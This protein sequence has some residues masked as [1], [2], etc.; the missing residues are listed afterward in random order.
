MFSHTW[1][2]GPTSTKSAHAPHAAP[3]WLATLAL[4]I[5]CVMAGSSH[6]ADPQISIDIKDLVVDYSWGYSTG[7][8]QHQ[9]SFKDGRSVH[10][11]SRFSR[12]NPNPN[13]EDLGN[14]DWLMWV[15]ETTGEASIHE[16]PV[17]EFGE[18]INPGGNVTFGTDVP[19]SD[20]GY[21]WWVLGARAE[22]IPFDLARS[23]A[24]FD[25]RDF[26]V[27]LN[28]F[29]TV[30]KSTAVTL[31]VKGQTGMVVYRYLRS[32]SP[33][34]KVLFKRFNLQ[35]G[36][37]TL[38]RVRELGWAGN[39]PDLGDITIEQ[40]WTRWDPRR[41]AMAAT[42]QW[43]AR[44]VSSSGAVTKYFGS[45]PFIYTE[46]FGETWRLADGSLATLP[47]TYAT[48]NATI[49]PY[50]HL[51]AH[52]STLWF[53]RD[54]G[55]T[56]NGTP[57]MAIPSGPDQ[58]MRFFYWAQNA[59]QMRT[60]TTDLEGGDPVACG[61]T[62]NYVVCLFS[63][64][65]LPG[66]LRMRMSADNGAT[67]SAPQTLD[68]IPRTPAG[69][70]QKIAWVSFVQPADGFPNDV[71]RFFYGYWDTNDG[72]N[73]RDYGNNMRWIR[74]ALANNDPT[75]DIT[76]PADVSSQ[77][78]GSTIPLIANTSDIDGDTV[79]VAW[80]ANGSSIAAPWTPTAGNYTVVA[81]ASD[82]R[83]GSATDS[84]NITVN[85]ANADPT[86]DITAPVDGS[87]HL[88]GTT[89]PLS[90]STDD[91]DGD[92]VTVAW[93][94]NGNPISAPWIPGAGTYTVV[95]NADDGNGGSAS[96]SVSISV[97]ANQDPTVDITAP[98]DG[99]SHIA[100]TAITLAA[101]TGD[102]DG[103]TVT[104]AW[105][106]NGNPI[107]EPWLPVA[108]SY[109]VAATASDGHGGSAND[110]VSITVREEGS[111]TVDIT[112]PL[113][114]SGHVTGTPIPLA[115]DTSD[116]DGDTVLVT[117]T[118][119]GTLIGEPWTPVAGS[120]TVVASADDGNGGTAT[121]SVGITVSDPN[122]DPT[123]NITSPADASSYV[124]GAPIP[125]SAD[126]DDPDGDT[127][128]VTW[129]ANGNPISA[130][131]A[132][133]AGNYTVVASADDGNGG[134]ASD[135]VSISV[136][137]NQNPT[138]DITSP[139]DGSSHVAGT[140]IALSATTGDPDGHTVTVSWTANG[141]AI[142]APWVPAAGNYTVVAS[143]SDGRGGTATDSVSVTVTNPNRNPTVDITSPADGSSYVSGSTI[144]LTATTGDPD[145]HPVAIA[146]TA[147]GN[148]IAAPWIPG[149]GTYT[150]VATASD[151]HG[152]TATDSVTT[153]V[154]AS[155]SGTLP[156]TV[157]AVGV[158]T[159]TASRML[160]TLNGAQNLTTSWSNNGSNS[161]AWFTLDLGSSKTVERLRIAP[162]GGVKYTF[163]VTIGN[164]V[165][166]G[167]V[168]GSASGTCAFTGATDLPTALSN[169]AVSGVG[170]YVTV[171][172]SRPWLVVYGVEAVGSAP[173]VSN[174]LPAT[175]HD[176]GSNDATSPR[177][178][179]L[180]NGAQN[181]TTNWTND[182]V[183]STAWFTLDLGSQ[184]SI[185][186]L[187]VA[188]RGGLKY[189]LTITIGN[190]VSGGKVTGAAT[191]TCTTSG[192]TTVPTALTLCGVSGT[193][194]YVTVQGNKPY[195]V[196]YGIEA[197][198]P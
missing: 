110:S 13:L 61:T 53:T 136:T 169:C 87:S 129:T 68:A 40:V 15:D 196:F 121:D 62:K 123:I 185:G 31:S 182:G 22:T 58:D 43:F 109:T 127:V 131:W 59:W 133:G 132:P 187:M 71:A 142:A 3:A 48:N 1:D 137:A 125:L 120:Y 107:A 192:G 167:K 139:V 42:W 113:D 98:V 140:T 11:V 85:A 157:L 8:K 30:D 21:M 10:A 166:G 168:S 102:A 83:G 89:I 164:T 94:A 195:L 77:E 161:T 193:G 91:P 2:L 88:A 170:R 108:G 122:Q 63:E 191:G 111:P 41:G 184:Q 69:A 60:L 197:W 130:G 4:A 14:P 181:L 24:P 33:V 173:P 101:S 70:L 55:F 150:V 5:V 16:H 74:V 189:T 106:A 18:G 176:A 72:A 29:E 79:T 156:A 124:A 47:L 6:A 148:P 56:P 128:A 26:D 44:E 12:V 92:T 36:T 172:G 65:A 147:N 138:V 75:V 86:I 104:V 159:A 57:W 82:G 188:P 180:L 165:S 27:V 23:V 115:A 143:A 39:V 117:W 73:G 141:S 149:A 17:G 178:I 134:S 50:D 81:T 84:V 76:S 153:T 171:Q 7:I 38:E 145:G 51:A 66:Q 67:W 52:E 90:A 100:G 45:N 80:T 190:T 175:I 28:D 146:W 155:G 198:K 103:H 154:T 34:G 177:I 116:P 158:N 162:N 95:A 105:T 9:G 114:G 152:G 19:A 49:S 46:D 93:T 35:P 144:A 119:N 151:G 135:T 179:D 174:V 99:S 37:P 126:T 194:R 186:R 118:A 96:D 25:P 163:T 64:R 54:I 160:D 97:T 32:T 78:V 20:T 183:N 112:S